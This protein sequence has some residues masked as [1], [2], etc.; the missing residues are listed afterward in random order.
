[1][2]IGNDVWIGSNVTIMSGVTIGDGAAIAAN[3]T[4][5]RDVD[6]YAIVA[7]NPA[8]LLRRRFDPETIERLLEVAWWNWSDERIE[9]NIELLCSPEV[10]RFLDAQ[11][12]PR[13]RRWRW[14]R[15]LGSRR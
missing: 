5:T 14:R 12:R 2:T 7:G 4:V 13:G 10:G 11:E 6:P 3:S 1:M 15:L 9:E 8:R